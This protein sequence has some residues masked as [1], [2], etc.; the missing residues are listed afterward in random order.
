MQSVSCQAHIGD[1]HS[2]CSTSTQGDMCHHHPHLLKEEVTYGGVCCQPKATWLVPDSLLAQRSLTHWLWQTKEGCMLPFWFHAQR[3][4]GQR[5]PVELRVRR[6]GPP[7]S[8]W[9][10]SDPRPSGAS[11]LQNRK[12]NG[13]PRALETVITAGPGSATGKKA[14]AL[15]SPTSSAPGSPLP[16][17]LPPCLRVHPA[18]SPA[19]HGERLHAHLAKCSRLWCVGVTVQECRRTVWGSGTKAWQGTKNVPCRKIIVHLGNMRNKPSGRHRFCLPYREPRRQQSATAAPS[20]DETRRLVP[21]T[22]LAA[23]LWGLGGC[24]IGLL[25]PQGT[26]GRRR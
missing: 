26:G 11:L 2:V 10:P 3:T 17:W 18:P 16:W 12:Q 15:E 22:A 4:P 8:C 14:W 24:N 1:P 25:Q 21:S 13:Q 7:R 9:L 5:L 19:G 20:G 6:R 23:V